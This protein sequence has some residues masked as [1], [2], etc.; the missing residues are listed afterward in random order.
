M[1]KKISGFMV[2]RLTYYLVNPYIKFNSWL[3]SA[4]YVPDTVSP[5]SANTEMAQWL[6]AALQFQRKF[7]RTP[8]ELVCFTGG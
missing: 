2:Y 5:D 8:Q 3:L 4:S 6:T 1:I 7:Y